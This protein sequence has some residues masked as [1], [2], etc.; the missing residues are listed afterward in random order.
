MATGTNEKESE[1]INSV[2][3][4]RSIRLN[5]DELVLEAR[6]GR[7]VDC[8]GPDGVRLRREGNLS[9]HTNICVEL[10]DPLRWTTKALGLTADLGS[11]LAS[12][13]MLPTR[14]IF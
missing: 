14:K 4:H 3:T 11:Q 9:F 12:F 1:G 6:V 7:E 2:C 10:R 5:S 13:G 8:D